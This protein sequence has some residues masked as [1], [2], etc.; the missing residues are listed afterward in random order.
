MPNDCTCCNV[1]RYLQI[2]PANHRDKSSHE[3]EASFM[4]GHVRPCVFNPL[5]IPRQTSGKQTNEGQT[6]EKQEH[7]QE[8]FIP[9]AFEMK[10]K[11]AHLALVLGWRD[12]SGPICAHV[13]EKLKL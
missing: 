5:L 11:I 8:Y 3:N 10:K 9:E 2:T 1:Q 12:V 6:Q 7:A 13:P 4:A